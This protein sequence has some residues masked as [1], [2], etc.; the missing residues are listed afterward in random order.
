[1]A[2]TIKIKSSSVAGKVPEAGSLVAAELAVN[3]ADKKLFTKNAAGEVI[4]LSGGVNSGGSG[5]KPDSPTP[6]DLF[7]D[8]DTKQ[9]YFWNGSQWEQIVIDDGQPGGGIALGE[10]SDVDT[11]GEKAGDVLAYD[12]SEWK[13]AD[14][15]PADISG[16][17]IKQLNDVC[18]G[19]T[20][21]DGQ[22]LHWVNAENNWCATDKPEGFSGDY[23]DLTNKPD[24]SI[25]ATDADLQQEVSDR[26]EADQALQDAIDNLGDVFVYMG[27]VDATA[28]TPPTEVTGHVYLNTG[29]GTA[30]GWTGLTEV[31]DGDLLAYGTSQWGII[32][33]SSTPGASTD[34]LDD[35]VKRGGTTDGDITAASFT[36][37]GSG[38][39][40]LA[41]DSIADAPLYV[42]TAEPGTPAHGDLWVDTN[43]CP[44]VIKIYSSVDSCPDDAGWNEVEGG[45]GAPKPIDPKPDDG[46]NE[47]DPPVSGDGTE[48]DPFVLTPATVRW[49]ESATTVETISFKD[50]T[51]NAQVR[52]V[53]QNAAANGPRFEQPVGVVALDGTF[54][55]QLVFNDSPASKIELTYTASFIVGE[56]HYT[57]DVTMVPLPVLAVGK[58]QLSPEEGETQQTF[59]GTATVTGA[60]NPVEVNVFSMDGVEVQRGTASTYKPTVE[61][62]LT[63]HK[64]VT[65]DENDSPVIGAES[66][67]ATVTRPPGPTATMS[68]LRFDTS[69]KPGFNKVLKALTE[70]TFSVWIKPTGFPSSGSYIQ[71][72]GNKAFY[73]NS[74]GNFA[75][76]TSNSSKAAVLNR[77]QHVVLQATA[78]GATLFVDGENCGVIDQPVTTTTLFLL[79]LVTTPAAFPKALM[80]I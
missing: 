47:I 61:G 63:Y 35:V 58:G 39:T 30:N 42:G 70:Y 26:Q 23:D 5:E 38:L 78:S 75:I 21:T 13:P 28:D 10:L 46:N 57:W 24:L 37:D 32:G 65:D 49:T 31:K 4:E 60:S 69:K 80:V 41:W 76:E 51:P 11:A 7:Y 25:Y 9:L 33:D 36:G 8:E 55:T 67:P 77:W 3:L 40:D 27:T 14:A 22:I 43:E 29:D 17:S 74:S 44:P 59:T 6:G 62:E 71:Q 48:L 73:I 68:G 1:M 19:M 20:P 2:T 53:D 54:S 56:I 79:L 18:D 52:F 45:G 72:L 50:Q 64:E 16:S 66:D 15:P 12:G 34:T